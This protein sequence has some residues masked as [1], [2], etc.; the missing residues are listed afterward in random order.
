MLS[1]FKNSNRITDFLEWKKPK[2]KVHIFNFFKKRNQLLVMLLTIIL[3]K[4]FNLFIKFPSKFIRMFTRKKRIVNSLDLTF[5]QKYFVSY[6]E[7]NFKIRFSTILNSIL[8]DGINLTTTF[9]RQPLQMFL[10]R[11]YRH[12]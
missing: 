1:L 11:M 4:Q 10:T 9:S 8:N 7:I 2:R 3:N 5:L 12:Y 6:M